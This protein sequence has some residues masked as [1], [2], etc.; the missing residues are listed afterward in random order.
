MSYNPDTPES[1]EQNHRDRIQ[2]LEEKILSLDHSASQ[3]TGLAQGN[4]GIPSTQL[5]TGAIFPLRPD[6]RDLGTV[7]SVTLN[8][9]LNRID[10]HIAKMI[11]NGDIGLAFNNPPTLAD[12]KGQEFW[13]Q[14]K[15]D[16]T[17]GRS[18]VTAPAGL[19]GG[20][21]G[22]DALLDKASNAVT[23][24]HFFTADGG[25]TYHAELIDSSGGIGDNLGNHTA[26]FPLNLAGN[27]IQNAL[28]L[29]IEDSAGATKL[30][31]SGP[32]GIGARLSFVTGE[33]MIFTENITDIMEID[34]LGLNML[35]KRIQFANNVEGIQFLDNLG[36]GY[37]GI[38]A[39]ALDDLRIK[40][41]AV[42]DTGLL[43]ESD[44]AT[45][46]QT[47]IIRQNNGATGQA[48]ID[49]SGLQMSLRV[50]S[51]EQVMLDTIGMKFPALKRIQFDATNPASMAKTTTQPWLFTSEDGVTLE[52]GAGTNVPF[53][54]RLRGD[55]STNAL[56][57]VQ[58]IS[59]GDDFAGTIVE[60]GIIKNRIIS[61]AVA[62]ETSSWEFEVAVAGTMT[63]LLELNGST[64]EIKLWTRTVMENGATL[65]MEE[66]IQFTSRGSPGTTGNLRVLFADSG[67]SHHLTI[68]TAAGTIDLEDLDNFGIEEVIQTSTSPPAG[69]DEDIFITNSNNGCPW[70]NYGS[71]QGLVANGVYAI[72]IIIGK[73]VTGKQICIKIITGQPSPLGRMDLGI[74]TNR[75][76]G[77]I[78]PQ[79]LLASVTNTLVAS[80]NQFIKVTIDEALE[81][82]LYWLA[83]TVD[84]VST[85][86]IQGNHVESC[87]GLGVIESGTDI[88]MLT[89]FLDQGQTTFLTTYAD[90]ALE[91][92][93]DATALLPAI[94]LRCE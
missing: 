23:V 40:R 9:E 50:N 13:L 19:K 79:T 27:P 94:Y 28:S 87:H 68:G 78:Y 57:P 25:S 10:S 84:N 2:D 53:L 72:P 12:L 7:G 14:I 3:R 8:I 54:L 34:N 88:D 60:Y 32:L 66:F 5:G 61:N 52:T 1:I 70:S 93:G 85:L 36:T 56:V 91:L 74:Y 59:E 30:S 76:D 92:T 82:G 37:I 39:T 73:A 29:D 17:G 62:L 11:V 35:S 90:D 55:F 51:L 16:V 43:L 26:A 49:T 46:P 63:K 22:I 48:L 24:L 77:A 58:I 64:D 67:N 4:A 71:G 75:T 83:M 21:A 38:L 42:G 44:H 69:S 80:D 81:P 47:L 41:S 86:V 18:I 45:D 15:Q 89:G 33:K 6:V 20:A 31:I 65:I